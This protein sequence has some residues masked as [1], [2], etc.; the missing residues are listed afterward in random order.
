MNPP[1]IL[2]V[3]DSKTIRLLIRRILRPFSVDLY[4]ASNGEEALEV[5]RQEHP[6]LIILDYNM[7]VMDGVTMLG[8]LR[9]D[10]L[11]KP[12]PV[13]MLTAESSSHI[14]AAVARLGA[15][16]YLTKPFQLA[17]IRSLKEG[18]ILV[19]DDSR[20]MR[21]VLARALKDLGFQNLT[22]AVNGREALEMV[23]KRP[24][25]SCSSTWKCPK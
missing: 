10:A 18:G 25:I 13:I 19:V 11:L 15:R 6:Q 23:Q 4:E 9:E 14:I 20:T 12:I 17:P 24:S 8:H 7:P 22:M 1:K 3:D 16:D 21:L 2:T 5:A